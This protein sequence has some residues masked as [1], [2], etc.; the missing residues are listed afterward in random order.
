MKTLKVT[1][2]R[3]I[4]K[5]W[6]IVALSTVFLFFSFRSDGIIMTLVFATI[7]EYNHFHNNLQMSVTVAH[8]EHVAEEPKF[9]HTVV[10]VLE[11]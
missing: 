1:L 11:H 9:E 4:L 3:Q 8:M 6:L 2:T 10:Y 7:S 5:F